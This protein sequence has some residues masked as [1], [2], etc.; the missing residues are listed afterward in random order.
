MRADIAA[1]GA[2]LGMRAEFRQ[3]R[4]MPHRVAQ[5]GQVRS[6]DVSR[7]GRFISSRDYADRTRAASIQLNLTGLSCA[8]FKSGMRTTS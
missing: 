3:R 2:Q 6:C 7:A 5:F 8:E 1:E 4:D